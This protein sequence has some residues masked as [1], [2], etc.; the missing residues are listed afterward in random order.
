MSARAVGLALTL[1]TGFTGL[2]YEVT[3]QKYLATL[4][5]SH[6]EAAAAVLGLFLGGLSLGYIVF[7]RLSERLAGGP[8]GPARILCAYGLAEAAIGLW[9][10]AFPWLFNAGWALSAWL[11]HTSPALGFVLDVLCSAALIGPPAVVM[12]STI[13]LLTQ[14]LSRGVDDS[15]RLH[16]LVYGLNTVGAFAG[17]LAAGFVLLPLLGLDGCVRAMAVINLAAGAAFFAFGRRALE[18]AEDAVPQAETPSAVDPSESPALRRGLYAGLAAT[19]LLIGFATMTLQM[20]LNR[21]GGL[22][23]GASHF[24]F[25]MVVSTFGGRPVLRAR[26]PRRVREHDSRLLPLPRLGSPLADRDRPRATGAVRCAP[27]AVVPHAA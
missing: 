23:L 6:S 14:A 16:A 22:S 11:P 12:G 15:T 18:S 20:T 13:P 7:G 1:V 19:A 3:W 9:A 25:A 24:T 17:A 26:D 2:V 4:L 8:H 21:I 10:L 5:G 27:A